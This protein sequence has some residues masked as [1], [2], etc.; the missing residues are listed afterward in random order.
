MYPALHGSAGNSRDLLAG[1]WV[2]HIK[3]KLYP[4]PVLTA[5]V[6]KHLSQTQGCDWL[7]THLNCRVTFKHNEATR[8]YLEGSHYIV[9]YRSPLFADNPY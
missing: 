2:E 3:Q 8:A 4:C 9:N 6:V 1:R 7:G 5:E